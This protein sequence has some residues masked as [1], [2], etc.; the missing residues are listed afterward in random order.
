MVLVVTFGRL[1][2]SEARR[3]KVTRYELAKKLGMQWSTVDAVLRSKSITERTFRKFAAALGVEVK[4]VRRK[5][6]I[7]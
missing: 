1:L 4:L 5:N 6:G 3:Q 7:T 2:R